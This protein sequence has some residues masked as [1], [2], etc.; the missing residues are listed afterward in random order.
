MPCQKPLLLSMLL[1]NI[2]SQLQIN[3][4]MTLKELFKNASKGM[5]LQ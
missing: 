5:S 3:I 4:L 1:E 2:S